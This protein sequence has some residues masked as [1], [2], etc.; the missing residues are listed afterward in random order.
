MSSRT[1]SM[2]AFTCALL[3]LG[4]HTA[5]AEELRKPKDAKSLEHLS[6]GNK[7]LKIGPASAQEAADQ[8]KA[9][10]LIEYAP[11]FDYNLGQCFRLLGDYKTAIWHYERFI[12][13][14]ADTPEFAE[15]ARKRIEEMRAELD[16]KARTSPPAEPEPTSTVPGS[17]P[18]SAAPPPSSAEVDLRLQASVQP[19]P[20]YMDAF[21]WGLAGTGVLGVGVS[22]ILL[23]DAAGLRDDANTASTQDEANTLHDRADKRALIGTI[24]GIG[25]AGLIVTGVIKLVVHSDASTTQQAAWGLGAS[26]SSAFVWGTF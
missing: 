17:T 14:S 2:L 4:A 18:A 6:R 12:R 15:K 1:M 25:G 20:W 10:L 21:G 19:S 16:Q 22:G 3:L 23:L 9:G 26:S 13:N 7:L 24:I 8:Y 5:S 11:I